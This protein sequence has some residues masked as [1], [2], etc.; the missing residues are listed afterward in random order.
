MH[1]FTLILHLPDIKETIF[2]ISPITTFQNMTWKCAL[3]INND[4]TNVT[5]LIYTYRDKKT[6]CNKAG[7]MKLLAPCSQRL[8]S[9][10]EKALYC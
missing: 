7:I 6:L 4:K 10:K 9:V 5:G 1:P 2:E 8:R 3:A